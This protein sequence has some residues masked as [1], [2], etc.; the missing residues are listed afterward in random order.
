MS[1]SSNSPRVDTKLTATLSDPDGG[2][3]NTSWRWQASNTSPASWVN[4]GTDS[5]YT[6]TSSDVGYNLRATVGYDDGHGSGK[7]AQGAAV[8]PVPSPPCELSVSSGPSSK[9]V[10]EN[11]TSVGT[12]TASASNCGSIS[13]SLG[14]PDSLAFA[15]SPHGHLAFGSAPDY[16]S[17]ADAN[18]DNV[19]SV[20]VKVTAAGSPSTSATRGVTVTVTN[21]NEPPVISGP[22][23]KSVA[24]N[25][26]TVATYTVSDPEGDSV[27]WSRTGTDAGDFRISTSGALTFSPAP[28]YEN[29]SDSD[30]DNVYTLNVVATDNRAEPASSSRSVTVTVTDVNEAPVILGAEHQVGGREQH[31]RGHL[32]GHRPGGR[33][34]H[35]VTHGHG[36][37][38]FSSFHQRRPDL[39]TGAELRESLRFEHRQRLH[40]ERRGHR[41]PRGTGVVKPERHRHRHQRRRGR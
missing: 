40:L 16:E 1:L 15:I 20:T 34:R 29:P 23:T 12:Y 35:V 41:Q 30:T 32:H 3:S 24:E 13:W 8:G 6:P 14:G 17:P 36:R 39:L 2:V 25:S 26:T 38:R 5:I 27:T 7:S 19:Y 18:T 37:G 11:S 9:S 28:N 21:V 31:H 10:A 33:Q 4:R 22:D